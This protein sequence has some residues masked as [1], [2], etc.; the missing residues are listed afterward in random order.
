MKIPANDHPD[1]SGPA[2]A[3]E[4]HGRGF[5]RWQFVQALDAA[6]EEAVRTW[7]RHGQPIA[8]VFRT[9][10]QHRIAALEEFDRLV[11]CSPSRGAESP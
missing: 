11:A 1:P 7:R 5:N 4:M 8:S 2:I 6:S 10:R 9:V 3:R